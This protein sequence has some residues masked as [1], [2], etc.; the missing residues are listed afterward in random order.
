MKDASN[1]TDGELDALFLAQANANWQK[2]AMV[3]AK[4]MRSYEQWSEGRVA[5]RIDALVSAG[6]LE[7]AGDIRRWRFSEVRLQA[8]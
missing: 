2:V 6:K 3:I 4:A 7:S 5:D 8:K 1:L